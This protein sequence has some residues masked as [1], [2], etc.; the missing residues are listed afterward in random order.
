MALLKRLRENEILT[1]LRKGSGRRA[2]VLCFPTL[3]DITEGKVAL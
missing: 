2:A 1:V 3:L